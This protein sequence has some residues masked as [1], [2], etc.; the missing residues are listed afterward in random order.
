VLPTR[1]ACRALLHEGGRSAPL[2]T[3]VKS[4]RTRTHGRHRCARKRLVCVR[5]NVCARALV[6]AAA[7]FCSSCTMPCECEIDSRATLPSS[8]LQVIPLGEDTSEDFEMAL[9]V[10]VLRKFSRHINVAR[11]FGAYCDTENESGGWPRLRACTLAGHVMC[12]CVLRRCRWWVCVCVCVCVCVFARTRALPPVLCHLYA[13]PIHPY[14]HEC[15]SIE[16]RRAEPT[17]VTCASAPNPVNLT[18]LHHTTPHRTTPHHAA[19]PRHALALPTHA[20]R[21][22]LYLWLVMEFCAYGSAARLVSK[23]RKPRPNP[24]DPSSMLNRA[25][26]LSESVLAHILASTLSGL[27]YVLSSSSAC[28]T[29]RTTRALT[30]LVATTRQPPP[31]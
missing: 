26:F 28:Y 25:G 7:T 14:R 17:V 4:E 12:S 10:D 13:V 31:R 3:T 1:A 16:A 2:H 11:F 5:V 15:F 29:A 23:V 19:P 30:S 21:I 8:H 6:C 20:G 27:E 18:E 9:E 22:K 24:D